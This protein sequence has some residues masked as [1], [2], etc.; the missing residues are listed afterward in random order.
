MKIAAFLTPYFMCLFGIF[1]GSVFAQPYTISNDGN[2]VTDQATGLVWRRCPEGLMG[3]TCATGTPSVFTHQEA[4]QHATSVSSP[5][6]TW[7]LPNIK[8]LASI[9]DI[10]R[11]IPAI[12]NNVFPATPVSNFWSS[13]PF[14]TN[15]AV[16]WIVNFNDGYITGGG[17]TFSYH[18][19]LVRTGL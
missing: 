15:G 3:S 4:L 2:E 11:I 7:R 16:V 9:V 13:T 19:R 8:E 18:V 12:D 1:P 6:V 10:G 14:V 5:S 17:R